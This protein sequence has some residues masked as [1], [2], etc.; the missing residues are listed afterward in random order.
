MHDVYF[1]DPRGKPTLKLHVLFLLTSNLCR[2]QYGPAVVLFDFSHQVHLEAGMNMI[3]T[4]RHA[5][6]QHSVK[7]T[8]VQLSMCLCLRGNIPSMSGIQL[9]N[10]FWSLYF[11]T[12]FVTTLICG[13]AHLGAEGPRSSK[14]HL[15]RESHPDFR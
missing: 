5:G 9:S 15:Q 12:A 1:M 7:H 2:I 8:Q 14:L 3:V 10:M 11:L 6:C 13:H 4:W